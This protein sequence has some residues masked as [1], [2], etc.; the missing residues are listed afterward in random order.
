MSKLYKLLAA[1]FSVMFTLVK[2]RIAGAAAAR[3]QR[4][5]LH[6]LI[7]SNGCNAPVLIKNCPM[8]GPFSVQKG[9]FSV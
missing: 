2:D 8:S 1:T 4:V 9:A 5:H 7:S 3:V 6:P